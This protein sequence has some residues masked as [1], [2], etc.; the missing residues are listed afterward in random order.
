[1]LRKYVELIGSVSESESATINHQDEI[2]TQK[3][4]T[5]ILNELNEL[6]DIKVIEDQLHRNLHHRF[7]FSRVKSETIPMYMMHK[8]AAVRKHQSL[9]L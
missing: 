6:K 5:E 1:M 4:C 8:V 9:L 3:E 7:S 2:C